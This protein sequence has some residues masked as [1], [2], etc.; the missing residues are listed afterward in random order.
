MNIAN[1]Q[2]SL[3]EFAKDRDWEQYHNPKNLAMALTVEAG[4][5]QEIFQWLSPEE[6]HQIKFNSEHAAEEI[7]DVFLYLVRIAD[8]LDIDIEQAVEMKLKKNS[9]KYPAEG[10]NTPR[11]MR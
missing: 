8:V 11:S 6:A 3:Q 4:E 5:L 9:D 1:L 2:K 7:A 10:S